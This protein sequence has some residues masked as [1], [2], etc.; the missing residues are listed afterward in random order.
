MHENDSVPLPLTVALIQMLLGSVKRAGC[1]RINTGSLKN[2]SVTKTM[3]HFQ[4]RIKPIC[5]RSLKRLP[6]DD[7]MS[8]IDAEVPVAA[9]HGRKKRISQGFRICSQEFGDEIHI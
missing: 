5:T 7:N 8:E 6:D 3:G 4:S 1:C 9:A 2:S